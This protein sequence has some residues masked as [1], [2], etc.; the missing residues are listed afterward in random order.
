MRGHRR[1]SGFPYGEDDQTIPLLRG[2]RVNVDGAGE[3]CICVRW[4]EELPVSSSLVTYL[5]YEQ[6]FNLPVWC[7]HGMHTMKTTDIAFCST[8]FG[9]F[10]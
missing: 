9:G 1:Q 6:R 5:A 7:R 2:Q 4:V 10:Q 8:L 3:Q